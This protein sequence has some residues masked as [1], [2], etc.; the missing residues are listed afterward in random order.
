MNLSVK[1]RVLLEQNEQRVS[2]MTDGL[3]YT[4]RLIR[5]A[6]TGKSSVIVLLRRKRSAA[7]GIKQSFSYRAPLYSTCRND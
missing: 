4:L 3:N 5:S 6:F 1:G 7:A 2:Y